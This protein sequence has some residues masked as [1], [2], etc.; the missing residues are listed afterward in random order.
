[1][2][3]TD[4]SAGYLLTA[5]VDPNAA[6][7]G[8]FAAYQLE[9]TDGDTLVGLLAEENAAGITLLQAGGVRQTL[10]RGDIKSLAG[11]KVSLMPEG[12]EQG[13]APQDV[14]DLIAFVQRPES[15]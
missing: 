8:R 14:A 12:L 1:M 10:A 13:L 7:E 11:S 15:K 6:V 5:I 9:T 3:L 2:A 4:K